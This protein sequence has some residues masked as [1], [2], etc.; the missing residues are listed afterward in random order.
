MRRLPSFGPAGHVG[1]GAHSTPRPNVQAARRN[2]S[3][4]ARCYKAAPS[5]RRPHSEALRAHGQGRS[6]RSRGYAI[7][8]GLWTAAPRRASGGAYQRVG[9]LRALA[10]SVSILCSNRPGPSRS[11]A[12]HESIKCTSGTVLVALAVALK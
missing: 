5:L 11:I 3:G 6:L 12:G 10:A 4:G 8:S 9:I 1:V 7:P 2:V